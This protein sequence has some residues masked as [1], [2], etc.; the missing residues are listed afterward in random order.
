MVLPLRYGYSINIICNV[1]HSEMVLSLY[2]YS[3]NIIC[4]V[5][6]SEMVLSLN[7]L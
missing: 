2:G 1:Y 6:H 7:Q 3:I 5:Y 4:N